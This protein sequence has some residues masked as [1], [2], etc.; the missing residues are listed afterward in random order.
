[1][2]DGDNQ[3]VGFYTDR[4]TDFTKY[5]HEEDSKNLTLIILGIVVGLIFLII[6]IVVIVILVKNTKKNHNLI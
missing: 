3:Q 5:V 6:I 1:M 2:Y 4:R